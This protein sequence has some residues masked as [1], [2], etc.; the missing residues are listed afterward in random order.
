M[1]NF[2]ALTTATVSGAELLGIAD[3]TG[4]IVEGYEAD[5]ILVPG[6]PLEHIEALQDVLMVMSNGQ[7]AVKRIPFG[8]ADN[9]P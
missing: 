7:L 8:L 1:T 2:D 5:L 6:N 3:S 4:R 9:R